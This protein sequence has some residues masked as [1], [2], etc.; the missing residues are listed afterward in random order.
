MVNDNSAH[1]GFLLA[2]RLQSSVLLPSSDAYKE[3]QASYWAANALLQPSCIVQPQTTEEVSRVLKVLADT[4]G[5]VAVRSGG[6]T[7]WTGSN[8]I[9]DGITIDLGRMT[10]VTYDAHSKLALIQPGGRWVDVYQELLKYQV[11]VTGG[12]DGNVGVGGFLTGGGNSYYAGL[13]GLGCDNIAN[14]EFVLAD[15]DI[16]NANEAS[17]S[18]LWTAL[19]GGSGNFGIVTRFDMYTFPAQDLWGGVRAA[20]RSEGDGLAQTMVDFTDQNH[21]NPQAA[22]IIN[23][24]FNLKSSPD[25]LV[26]HVIAETSGTVNASAFEK[27]METP[28][29][30]DDIKQRSM[31]DMAKTYTLPS[32]QQ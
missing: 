6:H 8:D 28:V 18:D 19:K 10:K 31:A 25:V 16:I 1:C 7:Q 27:I 11:C 22:Y 20:I 2:A 23:Y 30:V 17:H 4:D 21:K 32:H 15:G 29:V 26:A 14:F 12:R 13:Y 5:L 3:R 24:S 9:H